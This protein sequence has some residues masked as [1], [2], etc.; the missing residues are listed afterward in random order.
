M[1]EY[2]APTNTGIHDG[3]HR[4]HSGCPRSNLCV[5]R[6]RLVHRPLQEKEMQLLP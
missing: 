2:G 6:Y 5:D 4:H 3:P 1:L